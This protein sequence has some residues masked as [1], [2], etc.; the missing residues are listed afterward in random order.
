MDEN[1]VLSKEEM[2]DVLSHKIKRLKIKK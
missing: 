2:L 1:K